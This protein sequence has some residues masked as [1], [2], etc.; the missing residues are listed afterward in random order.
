MGLAPNYHALSHKA[1]IEGLFLWHNGH[2]L[3]FSWREYNSPFQILVTE[4]LL[5]KTNAEK[6]QEHINVVIS[7]IGTIPR[8]KNI[9]ENKLIELLRP[10]GM[11]HKKARELKLLVEILENEFNGVVPNSSE[12]L[13]KLPG[14]GQ[15]ISSAVLTF[16]FSQPKGVVDTNVIRVMDRFFGLK[17]TR[18][19]ARDDQQIWSFVDR[20][21][22]KNNAI[23]FNY[24]LIDFAK[25]V[26]TAKKP[27][28]S[29]C[30]LNTNCFYY[31]KQSSS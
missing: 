13:I 12:E 1:F 30:P 25:Q 16:G 17:S 7:Q 9:S 15:Y 26:C 27:H 19:R 28:C 6:V 24:A 20:L 29:E 11:Q 3:S 5:R 2:H 21:L 31:L 14:V 10:F 8:L 4:V 22:P 18:S 23:N